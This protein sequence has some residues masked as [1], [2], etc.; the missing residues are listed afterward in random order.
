MHS[1]CDQLL[2][3]NTY[4]CVMMMVLLAA[5]DFDVAILLFLTLNR[6]T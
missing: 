5:V 4:T 3:R 6:C 1:L 2:L